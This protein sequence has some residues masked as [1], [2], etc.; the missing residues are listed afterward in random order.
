MRRWLLL[1]LLGGCLAQLPPLSDF[2]MWPSEAPQ[3]C[4]PTR[5]EGPEGETLR[6]SKGWTENP[7]RMHNEAFDAQGA[8]PSENLVAL[9]DCSDGSHIT[10]SALWFPDYGASRKWTEATVRCDGE[11]AFKDGRLVGVITVDSPTPERLEAA[12]VTL[13]RIVA[14]SAA[15]DL[16]PNRG[17][18]A[19]D[20]RKD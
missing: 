9:F 8:R 7:G 20:P 18:D 17:S 6:R 12:N 10:S 14:N 3:D 2:V 19:R 5:A 11:F 16:C 1:V 15:A 4:M 13:Q